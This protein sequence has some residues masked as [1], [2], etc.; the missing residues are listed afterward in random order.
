M[1]KKEKKAKQNKQQNE[2]SLT[3]ITNKE[4]DEE[5]NLTKDM[6]DQNRKWALKKNRKPK[7]TSD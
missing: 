1:Q 3:N 7:Y 4:M 5:E 2:S 6:I